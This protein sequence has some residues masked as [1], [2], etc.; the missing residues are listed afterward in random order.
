M[1]TQ[2]DI[3]KVTAV[4]YTPSATQAGG[5]NARILVL[6]HKNGTSFHVDAFKVVPGFV[7]NTPI[8]LDVPPDGLDVAASDEFV[9]ITTPHPS[10][11]FADPGGV[12]SITHG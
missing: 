8:T 10:G 4:T 11:G 12:V 1:Q 5:G 7:A 9:W 3:G 2:M 6:G